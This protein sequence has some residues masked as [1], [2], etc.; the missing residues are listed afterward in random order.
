VDPE[1]KKVMILFSD[2]GESSS[3]LSF[4]EDKELEKKDY[5]SFVV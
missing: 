5:L 1:N 4:L 2:G 3:D